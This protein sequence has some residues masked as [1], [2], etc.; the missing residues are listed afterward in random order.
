[1]V[2][3]VAAVQPVLKHVDTGSSDDFIWQPVPGTDNMLAEEC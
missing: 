3:L 2:S 1:M